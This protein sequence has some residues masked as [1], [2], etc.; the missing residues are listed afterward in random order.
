M[1]V[2][3]IQYERAESVCQVCH[4]RVTVSAQPTKA[5]TVDSSNK[6]QSVIGVSAVTLKGRCHPHITTNKH[7]P[8]NMVLRPSAVRGRLPTAHPHI[9]THISQEKYRIGF[10]IRLAALRYE[11]L[12]I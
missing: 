11:L 1:N 9:N 6:E 8:F 5:P 10:L 2:N 7:R 4:Q 3:V 12:Q